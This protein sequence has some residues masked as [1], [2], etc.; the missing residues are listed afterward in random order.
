MGLV[1]YSVPEVYA[2][3]HSTELNFN[4]LNNLH[5]N[6]PGFIGAM[7]SGFSLVMIIT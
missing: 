3:P 6:L 2:L 7:Y 1:L 5:Y 4:N